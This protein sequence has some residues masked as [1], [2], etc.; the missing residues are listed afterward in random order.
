MNTSQ[1]KPTIDQSDI[2]TDFFDDT[3]EQVYSKLLTVELDDQLSFLKNNYLVKNPARTLDLCCGT[4]RHLVP[5][6]KSGYLVDGIDI[7]P[8]YTAVASRQLEQVNSKAMIF[9]HDAR[10][11]NSNPAKYQLVYS[12]ESSIG[13]LADQETVEIL[14]NVTKLLSNDGKFVLHLINRDYLIRN[15]ASRMWFGDKDTGYVLENRKVD[16]STGSITIEQNR[17]IN[18]VPHQYQTKLRLYTVVEIQSMLKTA[19]LALVNI[20]GDFTGADFTI[21]SPYMILECTRA[22]EEVRT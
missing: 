18:N 12:I 20:Y 21:N 17:I 1:L 3:Y 14:S 2:C 5:L 10:T 11:F 8:N 7:N 4:G 22:T 19:G 13:Y 15:L 6:N 16:L 9:T